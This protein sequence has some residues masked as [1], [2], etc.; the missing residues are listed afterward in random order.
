MRGTR[1]SFA[2]AASWLL[3][4]LFASVFKLF[5]F[6]FLY[7]EVECEVSKRSWSA[8]CCRLTRDFGRS[9]WL[10]SV[11][12]LSWSSCCWSDC[13]WS[14][15]L[16]YVGRFSGAADWSAEEGIKDR[17]AFKWALSGEE[18]GQKWWRGRKSINRSD[19]Y[20]CPIVA[21]RSSAPDWL[22][23]LMVVVATNN[24]RDVNKNKW[25]KNR[26]INLD[27]ILQQR[28]R[29]LMCTK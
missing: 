20:C 8:A 14:E 24:R 29:Q 12:E 16:A 5:S 13:S 7:E 18:M 9:S 22:S 28:L 15:A 2:L 11:A 19:T 6:I 27:S 21:N 4:F 1:I 26:L 3:F 25:K 23:T 10:K 17:S